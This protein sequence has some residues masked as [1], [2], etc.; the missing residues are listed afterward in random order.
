MKCCVYD[1]HRWRYQLP[2]LFSVVCIR[3]RAQL[4]VCA[5]TLQANLAV[6]EAKYESA[7]KDL[8]KAQAQLDDK[9]RELDVVRELYDQAMTEKQASRASFIQWLN[10]G[11]IPGDLRSPTS[12][13]RSPPLTTDDL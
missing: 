2:P 7:M 13:Y 4:I 10:W 6:Q 11:G 1:S 3:L 12:E 9:Q 5:Q 8:N